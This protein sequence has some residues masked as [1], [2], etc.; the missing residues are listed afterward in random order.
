[1]VTVKLSFGFNASMGAVLVSHGAEWHAVCDKDFEYR[2]A[3]VICRTLGFEDGK[4]LF[5]FTIG[6]RYHLVA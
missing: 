4:V 1:M 6:H 2:D 3:R 5:T